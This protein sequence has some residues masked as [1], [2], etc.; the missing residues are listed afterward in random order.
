MLNLLQKTYIV[1]GYLPCIIFLC[2]GCGFIFL[3]FKLRPDKLVASM[4]LHRW[5]GHRNCILRQTKLRFQICVIVGH[6]AGGFFF[7]IENEIE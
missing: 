6:D 5:V 4:S 1:P 3:L 2:K 7:I